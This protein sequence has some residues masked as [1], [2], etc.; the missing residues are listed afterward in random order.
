MSANFLTIGHRGARGL[1]PENTITSFLEA[2]RLGVDAI[3]L[4]VVISKDKQ[5]VVSHEPWMHKDFCSMPDGLPVQPHTRRKY[6][7]YKMNYEEIRRFDCGQRG[8]FRFPLQHPV[9]AY[10]PL[11]SEVIQ[12]AN[13][14]AAEQHL[15]SPFFLIEVKSESEEDNLFNPEPD[16][17]VSLVYNEIVATN[18]QDHVC[19]QSF[20]TRIL[21]KIHD[22]DSNLETALLVE[23]SESLEYN[24][25]L[26]DFLPETYSP[27]F[28]LVTQT[29]VDEVHNMNM[30]IVPWTVN[31]LSD[32][33]RLQQLGV[34]GLISDYPDRLVSF[35]NKNR[36]TC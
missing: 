2:M 19:V 31:E 11:L 9:P 20:D 32:M 24:L 21:N 28:A 15:K 1:Y 13:A 23:N 30:K 25:E 17:F 7:F 22:V 33:Q 3:E 29:L 27:D 16:E 12:K 36:K 34:D 18:M 10:K 35:K 6:N 14:Y 5:V 8:N 26:L 4:D